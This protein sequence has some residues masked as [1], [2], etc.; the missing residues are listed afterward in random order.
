MTEMLYCGGA[1]HKNHWAEHKKACQS[2]GLECLITSKETTGRSMLHTQK[3]SAA[4]SRDIVD[5][6]PHLSEIDERISPQNIR[7]RMGY[8]PDQN[9]SDKWLQR[10]KRHE[11]TQAIVFFNE[12][13]ELYVS[14]RRGRPE[15]LQIS[16]FADQL[17]VCL[18]F[19]DQAHTRRTDLKLSEYYRAT[20]TLRA[21]STK[22]R[23]IQGESRELSW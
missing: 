2:T 22:D 5:E 8:W 20:V 3:F 17:D 9:A 16:P 1:C 12:D 10:C 15:R 4:S 6:R 18:I 13:D 7:F 14:D 19:L 21:N 23:L 11:Q